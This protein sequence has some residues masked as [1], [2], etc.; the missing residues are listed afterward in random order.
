VYGFVGRASELLCC[1]SYG[2]LLVSVLVPFA[3]VG[4]DLLFYACQFHPFQSA[5]HKEFWSERDYVLVVRG[6]VSVIGSSQQ[7]IQFA[8]GMSRTVVKQ[9]VEP[10]QMQ[11]P[12]GLT[13]VKFLSCYKVF[14]VLVVS[15]DLYWMSR[16]FQEVPLL[17]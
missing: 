5:H 12:T 4:Q 11:G 10:S 16:P 8:H 9:E 13:I 2:F 15:P 3:D 7:C 17:F 6:S 14:E 1:L